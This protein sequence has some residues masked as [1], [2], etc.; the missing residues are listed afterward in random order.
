MKDKKNIE[1]NKNEFQFFTEINKKNIIIP[2]LTFQ[3]IQN[4]MILFKNE[5]LKDINLLTR[6][7]IEK[8]KKYDFTFK[9]EIEKLNNLLT[10]TENKINDLSDL[11]SLD[12]ETKR[13]LESLLEFKKKVEDY[14]ITNDI[15]YENLEK[16]INDNVFRHDSIF[17]DT[18]IYPGIIGP[19]CRFK[20]FHELID[21]LINQIHSLLK[22]KEKNAID[23]TLYKEKLENMISAFKLQIDNFMK[24]STQF[25]RKTVNQAEER[26]ND[27]F[28]K[29]DD[30]INVN[31]IQCSKGNID[32]ENKIN[33]YKLANDDNLKN[34]VEENSKIN[35]IINKL[36]KEDIKSIQDKIND[37]FKKNNNNYNR[38]NKTNYNN[39]RGKFVKSANNIFEKEKSNKNKIDKKETK[40]NIQKENNELKKTNTNDE[41]KDNITNITT[42][43][44]N[45]DIKNLEMKL[46]SFI[47]NEIITLSQNIN[48]SITKIKN[49]KLKEE[50]KKKISYRNKEEISKDSDK[51]LIIKTDIEQE[52][53]NS[54]IN[55]SVEDP[56][57]KSY[58]QNDNPKNVIEQYIKKSEEKKNI[59]KIKNKYIF[60]KIKEVFIE[61]SLD[62]IDNEDTIN[63]ETIK[64]RKTNA[65][66]PKL[67]EFLQNTELTKELSNKKS[68]NSTTVLPFLTKI[69]KYKK[70]KIK[71]NLIDVQKKTIMKNPIKNKSFKQTQ[72][73][74]QKTLIKPKITLNY[75]DKNINDNIIEYKIRPYSKKQKYPLTVE[76]KKPKNK[77]NIKEIKEDIIKTPKI[78]PNQHLSN[79]TITLQGARK[80]NYDTIDIPRNENKKNLNNMPSPTIYMNFP[81]THFQYNER[82]IESLHPLYRNKKF[83]KYIRPYI[84][85]L[86]NNYQTKLT[87]NEKKAM[88]QKKTSLNWNKSETNIIKNKVLKVKNE[89]EIKLPEIIDE[90]IKN[91]KHYSPG[92]KEKFKTI[93]EN[94]FGNFSNNRN[95]NIQD[96]Y[97]KKDNRF[98]L[99]NINE[100]AKFI[101]LKKKI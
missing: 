21:Y 89:K 32:L 5:I 99:S 41:S 69:K 39:Y 65:S 77:I 66:V 73:S 54:I 60:E 22:Y 26:I 27:I 28:M 88:S 18:V 8:H 63:I 20:N 87:H 44:I 31:R 74:P 83:S 57:R 90:E 2:E 62:N 10:N 11:V 51:Q 58:I 7:I 34:I 48:K 95:N 82:I 14:I 97:L 72:T 91:I 93:E 56:K 68:S 50:N 80:F 6:D 81:R 38:F 17:K 86:T 70:R 13:K 37:I 53:K 67:S 23:L 96:I 94:D 24:S 40:E 19:M 45:N 46:Q 30:L 92:Y 64:K 16:D 4:E 49:E 3:N 85:A 9:K 100:A 61:E 35:N 47:K 101:N 43:Q 79:F 78:Q 12:K 42:K 25:T 15:R 36:Q 1:N 75:I 59:V 71:K 55:I 33:D 84:S 52:K 76:T 98:T 29:Y